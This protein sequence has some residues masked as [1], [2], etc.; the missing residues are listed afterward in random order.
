[1]AQAK[2]HSIYLTLVEKIKTNQYKEMLPTEDVLTKE[3]NAS[4]NTIRRAISLLNEDGYTYSV[5]GRG[6]VI[7]ETF[8]DSRW[9]F[10]AETFGGLE[11]IK[12]DND[13]TTET[14]VTKF[15]KIVVQE[16]DSQRLPFS[17]GET[18]YEVER[19]RFL[20]ESRLILDH[21]YFRAEQV[22]EL[23]QTIVEESVYDYFKKHNLRL[24]AAKRR[25]LVV[26]ATSNDQEKLD[27]GTYNCVGVL[28]NLVYN[29]MGK[30]FEYTES[31]F[32]P[33]SFDLSYFVQNE[34]M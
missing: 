13:L 20:N 5:K 4:R 27:L 23:D 28:E 19:I 10:N 17:K 9:S 1:M 14:L 34:D 16:E 2:F 30:S 12:T 6:V 8:D 25:F 15:Q 11:A 21:S 32:V 24:A 29:D 33:G 7:L 18:L 22:P 3:F 26:A 31:R